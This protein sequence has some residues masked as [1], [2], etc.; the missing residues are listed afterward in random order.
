MGKRRGEEG[1]VGRGPLATGIVKVRCIIFIDSCLSCDG[2]M[3]L[4]LNYR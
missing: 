1:K 2:G 3:S 4:Y